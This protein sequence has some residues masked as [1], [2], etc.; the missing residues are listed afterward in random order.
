MKTIV[1]LIALTCLLG[2]AGAQTIGIGEGYS[3]A[4]LA[5]YHSPTSSTFEPNVQQYWGS[6][7]T[8]SQNSSLKDKTT[9]MDVWM[10]AFPL[11]FDAPLRFSTTS[12]TSNVAGSSVG[13]TEKNSQF[14]TR[15]VNSRFG[16]NQIWNFPQTNG[17]LI[18]YGSSGMPSDAS[19]GK[20]LTQNI[21]VFFSL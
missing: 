13:S 4:Q 21:A 1:A 12:F 14:L 9:N 19:K 20:I 7:I 15:D 3:S 17:S 2:V 6:Y 8:G 11:K 10:N 5:F 16:I 18:A